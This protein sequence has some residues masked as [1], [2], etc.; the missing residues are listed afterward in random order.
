MHNVVKVPSLHGISTQIS[1][2]FFYVYFH[3]WNNFARLFAV[4]YVCIRQDLSIH[5][6]STNSILWYCKGKTK[7]MRI[8]GS[9]RRENSKVAGKR[10]GIY[11]NVWHSAKIYMNVCVCCNMA[12][13]NVQQGENGI[14][15][16]F[17]NNVQH[18]SNMQV[19]AMEF[20]FQ[21]RNYLWIYVDVDVPYSAWTI[22]L[23]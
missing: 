15:G 13:C 2:V 11:C 1:F 22:I 9:A 17:D 20:S 23:Q 6:E 16:A 5:D 3:N 19:F 4:V 8:S 14:Y 12:I 18:C 21:T 7:T 10:G